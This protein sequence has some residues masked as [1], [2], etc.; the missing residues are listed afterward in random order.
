[1][2]TKDAELRTIT[3]EIDESY[4][5]V[6]RQHSQCRWFIKTYLIIFFGLLSFGGYVGRMEGPSV[7]IC[8]VGMFAGVLTF[9][10]GWVL[11]SALA[12][13]ISMVI[14]T[15]K[16]IAVSRARRYEVIERWDAE[17]SVFPVKREDVTC[18]KSV[19][20]LPYAFF[21]VNYFT[22]CGSFVFFMSVLQEVSGDVAFL[23]MVT[24]SIVAG[25]LYPRACVTFYCHIKAARA[26]KSVMEK[27]RK[28]MEYEERRRGERKA[29]Y[30]ERFIL[31]TVLLFLNVSLAI[32]Q[33]YEVLGRQPVVVCIA[34]TVI[35]ILFGLERCAL[36]NARMRRAFHRFSDARR[37]LRKLF[38]KCP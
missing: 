6:D 29:E 23:W 19:E 10:M 17:E 36:D 14:L 15:Y 8:V 24:V 22:L 18:A 5:T 27:D 11:M 35:A 9:G 31:L 38:R 33:T 26:A 28:Y 2:A 21:G 4:K 3:E 25:I 13:K 34:S 12:H 7:P 30:R 32:G 1:M 37:L 16:Q 20:Y